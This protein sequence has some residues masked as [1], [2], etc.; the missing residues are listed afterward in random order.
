MPG[1]LTV[2]S[3]Q[4]YNST[5]TAV[6]SQT[7]LSSSTT[8]TSRSVTSGELYYIKVLPYSSYSGSYQIIF[9]TDFIPP[10]ISPAALSADTWANG[11]I[12]ASGN[13]QQWFTFTATD[14][15]Q[16]IHAYFGTLTDLFVQV[17]NSTGTAVGS[18]TNLSSSTTSTSRSVTNGSVY[19]IKVTSYSSY[20]GD[21]QIAFNTDFIPPGISPAAL[22]ADTWA[23]G[24][25]PAS[26]NGQQWFTFTATAETQYIHVTFGTLTVLSVQ[27]YNSTGTAVGSQT[28]LY[29]STT[30]TSRSVTSGELYYIRVTPPSSSYSGDY[31]IG[32][33]A[34]STAP[35]G[36]GS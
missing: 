32:F 14:A 29:S 24:D 18:Q 31:Q 11:N 23:A 35:T 9:N 27:V 22:T 12:P 2:L 28:N 7:N 4:V 3:V 21:Y 1:T 10:G 20:S 13:R 17:Y 6:G 33:T 8:S 36:G 5:G 19:Y 30:S 16:Y 15:T 25:I 26:G 34:S